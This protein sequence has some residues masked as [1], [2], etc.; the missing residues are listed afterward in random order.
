MKKY[1]H[2]EFHMALSFSIAYLVTGSQ[3]VGNFHL[4][5]EAAL[6]M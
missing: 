2:L 5:L 4:W 1:F 3:V 6:A